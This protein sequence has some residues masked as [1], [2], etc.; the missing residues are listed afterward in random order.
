MEPIPGTGLHSWEVFHE[1]AD[2]DALAKYI[3]MVLADTMVQAL[4]TAA[5]Y[6]EIPQY[7]LIVKRK[8]LETQGGEK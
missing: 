4:D 3:G 6:F 1:P 2:D 5:Q 7:D 8:Y